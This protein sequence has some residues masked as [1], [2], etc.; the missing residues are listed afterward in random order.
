VR[1]WIVIVGVPVFCE[2]AVVKVK[3][4]SKGENNVSC[5]K[6]SKTREAQSVNQIVL[7]DLFPLEDEQNRVRN[8]LYLLD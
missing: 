1:I 3:M 7:A 8:R 2:Q 5:F 6:G 4:L